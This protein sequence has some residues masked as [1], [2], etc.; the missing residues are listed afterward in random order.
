MNCK[1]LVL[2]SVIGCLA[3]AGCYDG[4]RLVEAARNQAIRTRLDEVD[5]GEY[6]TTLPRY[7]ADSSAM[8]IVVEL[9][10]TAIRYKIPD[11]EKTIEQDDYRLRQAVII[12]LRRT[13]AAE[14]ADPHLTTFRERLLTV[15]NAELGET[16]IES[17]GF[18]TVRFIPL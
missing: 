7:D 8:E 9:Y 14:I 13:T 15:V 12:A 3:T 11:V 16:P 10:G 2:L 6:R 5:L 18:R 4:K 17:L 1:H